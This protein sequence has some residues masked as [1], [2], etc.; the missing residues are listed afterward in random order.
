MVALSQRRQR[1][2][3]PVARSRSCD[4]EPCSVASGCRI[5]ACLRERRLDAGQ[6]YGIYGI[7][8]RVSELRYSMIQRYFVVID[9]RLVR[10]KE[11]MQFSARNAFDFVFRS[12][13]SNLS[14]RYLDKQSAEFRRFRCF[15]SEHRL[16]S[17][18]SIPG[19][20]PAIKASKGITLY[21]FCSDL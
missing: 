4:A 14:R 2:V 11:A 7:V 1:L 18:W 8:L 15:V 9:S 10:L 3:L 21:L 13:N 5:E 12:M 17:Q 20:E 19:L 6:V 16:D